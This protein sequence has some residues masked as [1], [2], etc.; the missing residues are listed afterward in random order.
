MYRF[1]CGIFLLF[2][3]SSVAQETAPATIPPIQNNDVVCLVGDSITHGGGYEQSLLELLTLRQPGSAVKFY[4]CGLSGASVWQLFPLFAQDVAS[5]KPNY[6]FVMMGMNDVGRDHYNQNA[7]AEQKAAATQKA[8]NSFW[9]NL[10]KLSERIAA[11]QPRNVVYLSPTPYDEWQRGGQPLSGC[12]T[13]LQALA[14]VAA[15]VA[16]GTQAGY[17]NLHEPVLQALHEGLQQNPPALL[18]GTDHVHPNA[19][20]NLVMALLLYQAMYGD[21]PVAASFDVSSGKITANGCELTNKT[22]A[23]GMVSLDI[24]GRIY[25][26]Y[27]GEKACAIIPLHKL[28]MQ[29]VP[30]RLCVTGLASGSYEIRQENAVLTTCSAAEL[31]AGVELGEWKDLSCNK[32]ARQIHALAEQRRNK[33]AGLRNCNVAL[34]FLGGARERLKKAGTP[35][36]EDPAEAIKKLLETEKPGYAMYM[37]RDYLQYGTPEAQQ[38]ALV[39]IAALEQQI[40][41]L[42]VPWKAHITITLKD[43]AGTK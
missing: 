29:V 14:E 42:A 8:A 31:S 4:N 35:L 12:D 18:I 24:G 7:T 17:Y 32:T 13:G 22:S 41:Q 26:F 15:E 2:C 21:T 1:I 3:C 25:P 27:V 40:E 10:K 16:K 23:S 38:K 43:S 20:G 19:F 37:Y 39:E 34:G 9:V 33:E 11:I 30:F 28:L 6:V 36:P 5:R